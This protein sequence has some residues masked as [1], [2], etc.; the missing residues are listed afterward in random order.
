MQFKNAL[1]KR[2][3][4]SRG[5]PFLDML[6]NKKFMS[7]HLGKGHATVILSY[8]DTAKLMPAS[9]YYELKESLASER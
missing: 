5:T 9:S 7:A 8:L 4:Q 1:R 2:R 6:G 3:I